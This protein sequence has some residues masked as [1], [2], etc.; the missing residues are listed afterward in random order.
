[1]FMYARVIRKGM[2]M[3]SIGQNHILSLRAK[4]AVF[5]PL[6]DK[7]IKL[8][9]LLHETFYN[10]FLSE[11]RDGRMG[12]DTIK[13]TVACSR[14]A[15]RLVKRG[16]IDVQSFWAVFV[17]HLYISEEQGFADVTLNTLHRAHLNTAQGMLHLFNVFSHVYN[18]K[19]VELAARFLFY[20]SSLTNYVPLPHVLSLGYH[21][22][23]YLELEPR[24]SVLARHFGVSM[25]RDVVFKDGERAGFEVLR[26]ALLPAQRYDYYRE[27]ELIKEFGMLMS[28]LRH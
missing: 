20:Y 24:M 3:T 15:L 17:H 11:Y 22:C 2:R 27:L 1:M 25:G 16:K 18:F 23:S 28:E 21:V 12:A 6:L 19:G 4:N 10:K 9:E 5:S 8:E 7:N 26:L 14:W 13:H